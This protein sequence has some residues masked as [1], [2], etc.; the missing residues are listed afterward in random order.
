MIKAVKFGGSSLAEAS[1]FKKVYDIIKSDP[2][3]K[4]VVPSA[5]GKR[6]PEDIKV[7][8]LLYKCY[9]EA[10]VNSDFTET[11]STIKE[12]YDSIIKELELD[13]S[14]DE[15]FEIIKNK[16]RTETDADYAAS[17][18]EYL[19][20]MILAK[21]LD[22]EFLDAASVIKFDKNGAFLDEE[23]NVKLSKTLK[24]MDNAVIPGF[25]GS[26]PDGSV[27]TFSRGGSDIT[28]S[29]LARAIHADVYENWTDVSGFKAADPRIVEGAKTIDIITYKELRE[30]S[31]MGAS[32]LH[33]SAIFPV[34]KEGIP[35][36]IKNTNSPTDAGTLIVNN[37]R[38]YSDSQDISGIS[39]AKNYMSITVQLAHLNE[40]SVLR[41]SVMDMF[42]EKGVKI[43][44][45][46]TGVDS[47]TLLV[48]E[49]YK[50][51]SDEA[52]AE[53]M[54]KFP[55]VAIDI[56]NE[57]AMIGVVGRDLGNSPN[58]AIKILSALAALRINIKFTAI[59][60]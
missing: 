25:Y 11:L 13:L 2:D 22:Y 55:E 43:E 18:G 36:N 26:M 45:M 42:Y 15:E 30:L 39:G 46:T 35:I 14:L 5:P 60:V 47:M 27:K 29:I 32:V 44:T 6:F 57:L 16:L 51:Q 21:Y 31:Y 3:R 10:K 49:D 9:A 24:D 4:Y 53:I 40:Q 50:E 59:Y 1:Q 38:Y 19:N 28:G 37:A 41:D 54:K 17:R 8:D 48:K 33:E 23:T 52:I 34:R 12:R 58:I 7:T 56:M 20:G